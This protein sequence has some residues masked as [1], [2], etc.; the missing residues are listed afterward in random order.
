MIQQ[1]SL[2]EKFSTLSKSELMTM[3]RFGAN[4]IM[5]NK[6][7]TL[8][9]EDIEVLLAKGEQRTAADQSK[10][11]TEMQHSLANFSLLDDAPEIDLFTFQGEDFKGRRKSHA[12]LALSSK[13]SPPCTIMPNYQTDS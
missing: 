6:D 13:V 9:D 5:S 12:N 1:G 11:Q 7:G 10:L 2:A 3:V 8:T 4:E